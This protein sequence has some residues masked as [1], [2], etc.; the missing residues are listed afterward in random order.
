MLGFALLCARSEVPAG[1]PPVVPVSLRYLARKYQRM[2]ENYVDKAE[3]RDAVLKER[4]ATENVSA[5]TRGFE[6]DY[7]LSRALGYLMWKTDRERYVDEKLTFNVD[8]APLGGLPNWSRVGHLALRTWNMAYILKVILGQDVRLVRG[9]GRTDK[10][11]APVRGVPE[12]AARTSG[13]LAA[14]LLKLDGR[15]AIAGVFAELLFPSFGPRGHSTD[16]YRLGRFTPEGD[17]TKLR[18]NHWIGIYGASDEG[19]SIRIKA[20]SWQLLFDFSVAKK[21]LATWIIDLVVIEGWKKS[22]A[23]K[24][25]DGK[26]KAPKKK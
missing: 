24:E 6:V 3:D 12:K 20:W 25:K 18:Y 5:L 19:D 14:E 10:L 16:N 4:A 9:P 22:P 7:A 26:G 17:N 23:D 11:A 1:A 21:D 13:D 2:A 8:F 15:I